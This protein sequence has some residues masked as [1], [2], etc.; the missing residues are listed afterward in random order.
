MRPKGNIKDFFGEKSES[1]IDVFKENSIARARANLPFLKRNTEIMQKS[2]GAALEISTTIEH[3]YNHIL[4]FMNVSWIDIFSLSFGN[5]TQEIVKIIEKYIEENDWRKEIIEKINK[6]KNLRNMYAHIPQ[7]YEN[8]ILRFNADEHYYNKEY[9]KRYMNIP[10]EE[11]NKEFESL[12]KTFIDEIY[13][14]LKTLI[15]NVKDEKWEVKKN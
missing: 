8:E 14:V 1:I 7:D 6:I 13:R 9:L 2:R 5:K 12:S 15:L 10:L 3:V 4:S 11:I